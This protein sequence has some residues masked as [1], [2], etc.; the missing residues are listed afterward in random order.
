M[1]SVAESWRYRRPGPAHIEV[2]LLQ[3]VTR[4]GHRIT[5]D[6]HYDV[7][8]NSLSVQHLNARWPCIDDPLLTFSEQLENEQLAAF[9]ETVNTLPLFTTQAVTVA[10]HS[11]P[12]ARCDQF[13]TQLEN[14]DIV[15]ALCCETEWQPVRPA[16][17]LRSGIGVTA[18]PNGWLRLALPQ[19]PLNDGEL[20]RL[21]K[22]ITQPLA[23]A[24]TTL[25]FDRRMTHSRPMSVTSVPALM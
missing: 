24:T 19:Q 5:F 13:A 3:W 22:A 21:R 20:L 25:R 4:N 23:V 17:E 16:D 12:F 2:L 10:A 8:C 15:A 18:Y 7:R 11:A 14:A 6:A 1:Q 9:T